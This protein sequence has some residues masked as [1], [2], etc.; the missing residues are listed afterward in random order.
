MVAPPTAPLRT[1]EVC[2][3]MTT[4]GDRNKHYR[5][6]KLAGRSL[7]PAAHWRPSL[8][9]ISEDDVVKI[10]ISQGFAKPHNKV[11][12]N[13]GSKANFQFSRHRSELGHQI[14]YQASHQTPYRASTPTFS[15]G[16]FMF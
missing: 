16:T 5:R 10:E 14:P 9:T 2:S 6:G 11:T 7:V 15:P 8:C 3:L 4:S 1:E 12:E 13:F